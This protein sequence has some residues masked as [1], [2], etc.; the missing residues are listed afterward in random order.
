[1]KKLTEKLRITKVKFFKF[2]QASNVAGMAAEKMIQAALFHP[3]LFSGTVP[4]TDF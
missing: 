3:K 1:M 4:A 2:S